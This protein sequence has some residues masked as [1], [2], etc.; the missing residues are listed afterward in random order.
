MI[1]PGDPVRWELKLDNLGKRVGNYLVDGHVH[2]HGCFD[3]RTFFEGAARNIKRG[4]RELVLRR[5]APGVLMFTEAE[6]DHYF[7]TFRDGRM[8]LP[9][10]WD[11]SRTA[12]SCS[13]IARGEGECELILIAGRQLATR[14]GLE[15]LAIGHE[16][17]LPEGRTLVET[18]ENTL[19]SGAL[20]VIP[21]GFGKWWF[22]RGA[23]V[24]EILERMRPGEVYL[25]DNSGRPSLSFTPKL[26]HR[27]VSNGVLIL[28]GSDPL[29][30]RSQAA[31]PGRYGFLLEGVLDYERP[32]ADLKR[33][34]RCL[35]HQPR[36]YGQRE[37]ILGF[38]RYQLAMQFRKRLRTKWYGC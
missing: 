19:A 12:E 17:G 1:R 11:L 6:G 29:P 21:W 36:T 28:P 37:G 16:G 5:E 26:F 32:A 33:M 20:P 8:D 18:V 30:F 23:L 3:A 9:G 38:A 35:G 31:R 13:L 25:G 22:A 7:Q 10:S 15:V 4:A 27:A 24:A 34:I 2:Y 14:E